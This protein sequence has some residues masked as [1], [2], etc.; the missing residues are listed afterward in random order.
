[1]E[2]AADAALEVIHMGRYQLYKVYSTEIEDGVE[3][4]VIDPYKSLTRAFY[5]LNSKEIIWG[6]NMR[7][8]ASYFQRC[9]PR[10]V[11]NVAWEVLVLH[12]NM[13]MLMPC[14][15]GYIQL[16]PI[17]RVEIINPTSYRKS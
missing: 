13:W 1:M 8:D 6:V 11:Q 16:T 9:T 7:S 10:G 17:I 4:E 15:Q 2:K 14:Q 3:I 5:D 12:S